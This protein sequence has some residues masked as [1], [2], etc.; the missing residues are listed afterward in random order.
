MLQQ[1]NRSASAQRCRPSIGHKK[2]R[3]WRTGGNGT[4][5]PEGGIEQERRID[6]T[7][8][9]CKPE[10]GQNAYAVV[11]SGT[12]RGETGQAASDIV[13]YIARDALAAPARRISDA[14]C[15]GAAEVCEGDASER[16]GIRES[17]PPDLVAS[18]D[19]GI[20]RCRAPGIDGVREMSGRIHIEIL[21][22]KVHEP[23]V[24]AKPLDFTNRMFEVS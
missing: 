13:L 15:R 21:A 6:H 1:A 4:R 17:V 5:R 23:E 14:F 20:G 16:R 22:P 11:F 8:H 24:A 19:I 12:Q 2:K 7:L 9:R 3:A 10:V 18:A